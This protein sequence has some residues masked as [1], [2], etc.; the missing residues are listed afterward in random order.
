MPELIMFRYYNFKSPFTTTYALWYIR[1][2]SVAMWVGNIVC[3]WQLMQYIFKFRSFD[4]KHAG[5]VGDNGE[6]LPDTNLTPG[7]GTRNTAWYSK[8]MYNGPLT[9]HPVTEP[10]DGSSMSGTTLYEDKK[11]FNPLATGKG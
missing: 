3:C 10:G 6:L 5:I 7:G 11:P 9:R 2:A 8:M 4:D 1:E